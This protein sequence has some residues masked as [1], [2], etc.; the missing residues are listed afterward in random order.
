MIINEFLKRGSFF[1]FFFEL[2]QIGWICRWK[3]LHVRRKETGRCTC[4]ATNPT[5]KIQKV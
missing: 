4:K 5:A 2:Y 1:C 3:S